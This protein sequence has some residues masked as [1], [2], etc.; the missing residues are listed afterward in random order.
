MHITAAGLAFGAVLSDLAGRWH[1]Y[2]DTRLSDAISPYDDMFDPT[3]SAA[4]DHYGRVGADA[5]RVVCGALMLAGKPTVQTVLD[6][7]CGGGRVTRHLVAFFPDADIYVSDLAPQKADFCRTTFGCGVLEPSEDF[8][9]LV[10]T[11]QFDV[12]FCGSL[13]THLP[14]DP[15]RAALEFLRRSLAAGGL[16]I[17]TFHG[18]SS[19]SIQHN[20]RRYIPDDRFDVIERD[21]HQRGFGYADYPD[22]TGYGITLSS[23]A[24]LCSVVHDYSDMK[25]ESPTGETNA[26]TI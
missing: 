8:S 9:S 12:I 14:E 13:L 6:L 5:M 26:D 16:A 3:N 18:R 23:P 22:A 2:A 19:L 11:R 10:P 25:I 1:R 17:V 20:R 7:P 21:F 24:W 4:M 15:A